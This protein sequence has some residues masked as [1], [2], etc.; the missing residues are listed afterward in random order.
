MKTNKK[1]A[2]FTRLLTPV[3][4]AGILLFASL[5]AVVNITAYKKEQQDIEKYT[6]ARMKS[7]ILDLETKL[8]SVESAL[9]VIAHTRQATLTDS[10]HLYD[11][12]EN[13]LSDDKFI[14]QAGMEFWTDDDSD[15]VSFALNTTRKADG[16]FKQKCIPCY[17]STTTREEMDCW[18]KAEQTGEFTWSRPYS[19]KNFADDIVISCFG[20]ADYN[21]HAMLYADIRL[22]KL[23]QVIDSLQ[24]YPESE[25]FLKVPDGPI[26]WLDEGELRRVDKV[27]KLDD[28]YTTIQARYRHLDLDIINMVPKKLIVDSL[29]KS[30]AIG[31]IVFLIILTILAIII[32]RSFTKAQEDL[33][34]LRRI[35]D[36]ISIAARIQNEMLID[37][38]K[39]IYVTSDDGNHV[40]I[41]PRIIPAREVGGDFYEY[42]QEGNNLVFCIG[43]V[44]GKGIPASMVM[45]KCS[46]LFHAYVSGS[47]EPDPADFLKYL[48]VQ[49]CRRNEEM[50]FVTVWAGVLNLKTGQLNYAS[51]GH[52]Q[53][54]LIRSGKAT[55]IE[56]KQGL[57][58]GMFEDVVFPTLSITLE[59]EDG[60]LLYT[61]GITE[62]EGPNHV[63]FGDEKLLNVCSAADSVYP[64]ILC[65]SILASVSEHAAG[66]NQSDDITLLSLRWNSHSALLHGINEITDLHKLVKEC[67][68]SDEA[69]LAL[70]EATVNVFVHGGATFASAE[71][72]DG[73]FIL[74]S[75]GDDFDP[76]KYIVPTLKPGEIKIGGRGIPL[77]RQI[78]QNITYNHSKEGLSILHLKMKKSEI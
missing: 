8:M 13:L 54:V 35:E 44:S 52:N 61:D 2:S 7:L 38:G 36:E 6:H 19:D 32:H 27:G 66:C 68:E 62:A 29:W 49:L 47:D 30:S 56:K 57:P 17:T 67:K 33:M 75:D 26:Y 55:F 39:T 15:T 34:G 3:L 46:T 70:E 59:A 37:P 43:D 21:N 72:K 60:L 48:N 51:A 28:K 41:M 40:E 9:N 45:S 22:S 14:H 69:A 16:T 74:I 63:L 24:F 76:T 78:C 1:N 42:R 65:R 11:K 10:T 4:L 20:L 64:G 31:F 58:L 25:M 23:L 77:M 50:M 73:E 53:P 71:Y 5:E 12:F 18:D